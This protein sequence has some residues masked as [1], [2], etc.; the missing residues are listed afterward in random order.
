MALE[1]ERESHAGELYAW[2]L[3]FFRQ[4]ALYQGPRS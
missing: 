4:F 1:R 2:G 3:L